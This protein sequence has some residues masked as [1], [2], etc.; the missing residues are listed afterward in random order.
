[1]GLFQEWQITPTELEEII[2]ANPSLRGIT[3]G[4]VAEYKLRKL[5]FSDP[6]ISYVS[7]IDDHSRTKKGDLILFYRQTNVHVEV[8]SIQTNSIRQRG[9]HFVARFQCDASDRRRVR[10][11]NGQEIETTCLV[12]GE[13]DLLAVNLFAFENRWV[14]AFARNLDLPRATSP[15]YTLEQQKFLLAT[16]MEITLPLQPPYEPEPFRL[17]DE[18]VQDK[19]RVS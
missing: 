2:G 8:K 6:R 1:M 19:S 9:A 10:L 15:K 5:W 17:L 16:Q 3:F 14:F 12:V 11:P 7:K 4:Y 18:I 13:F